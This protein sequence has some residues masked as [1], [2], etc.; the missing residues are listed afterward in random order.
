MLFRSMTGTSVYRIL[1]PIL[2]GALLVA[3][4]MAGVREAA[5]P[6]LRPLK[7]KYYQAAFKGSL[8]RVRENLVFTDG[9]GRLVTVD[10]YFSMSRAME[11]MSVLAL[12]RLDSDWERYTAARATWSEEP[13]REGW[14]L[15]QGLRIGAGPSG[16]L[17]PERVAF[18]PARGLDPDILEKEIKKTREFFD[19]SYSELSE[20]ARLRPDYMNFQVL[21]H[22]HVTFPLANL[23]LLLLALPFGV[24]FERKSSLEGVLMAIVICAAYLGLDYTLRNL[25]GNRMLNPVA[26]A[27]IGPVLFGS[28]GLA[29]F[30]SI[31]T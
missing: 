5:L 8:E 23:L 25:G 7:E 15:E 24:H 22:Y 26:A 14:L 1:I 16:E 12:G 31:R 6:V 17:A 10:N 9:Q 20:L 30:G 29:I 18:M 28:A 27:W 11:G 4:L 3:G 2:A 19:F 21:L 13:G